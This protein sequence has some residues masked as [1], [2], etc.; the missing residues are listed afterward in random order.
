MG[1]L[2]FRKERGLLEG[3]SVWLMLMNVSFGG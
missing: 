3:M 2:R 1:V